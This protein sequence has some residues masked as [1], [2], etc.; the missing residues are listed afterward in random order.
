MSES[1]SHDQLRA[2]VDRILRMREEAKA[3]ATDI[4][5][6]YAEAKGNGFDK[7]A[8]GRL[9]LHVERRATK[10]AEMAEQDAL[11]DAYLAAYDGSPSRTHAHARASAEPDHDPETGEIFEPDAAAASPAGVSDAGEVGPAAAAVAAASLATQSTAARKDRR[12]NSTGSALAPTTPDYPGAATTL[13][14]G[15]ALPVDTHQEPPGNRPT[16]PSRSGAVTRKDAAAAAPEPTITNEGGAHESDHDPDHPGSVIDRR[17]QQHPTDDDHLREERA[18]EM[19][20]T[21]RPVTASEEP[22]RSIA[23]DSMSPTQNPGLV[24]SS[25]PGLRASTITRPAICLNPTTCGGMGRQACYSC[26]KAAGSGAS[27]T[28]EHMGAIN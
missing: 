20:G 17:R 1:V 28:T 9:V 25:N 14:A 27:I 7:T 6:I 8:L 10:R 23:P 15:P 11:F 2:F 12:D 24:T 16:D 26:R 22:G 19:E 18:H 13:P 3:I 5:E 21:D 4:R